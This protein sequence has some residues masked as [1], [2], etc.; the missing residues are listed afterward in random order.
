M[1]DYRSLI[2][3]KDTIAIDDNVAVLDLPFD[4]STRDLFQEQDKHNVN[5]D[6]FNVSRPPR[7]VAK[8]EQWR[9]TVTPHEDGFELWLWAYRTANFFDAALLR[10]QR[11][12]GLIFTRR[13]A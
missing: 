11:Y 6:T 2:F 5:E 10:V 8:D 7:S 3:V 12:L 9:T 13:I 1:Y 4:N